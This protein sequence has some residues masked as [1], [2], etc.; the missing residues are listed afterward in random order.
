MPVFVG[1]QKI[2]KTLSPKL[3]VP[4]QDALPLFALKIGTDSISQSISPFP[5]EYN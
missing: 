3:A 4:F 1:R 2:K 5:L